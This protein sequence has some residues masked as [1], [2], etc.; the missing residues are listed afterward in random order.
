M[1][2]G[3][4][5]ECIFIF[6]CKATSY[7]PLGFVYFKDFF[8]LGVK[9]G[10]NKLQPFRNVFMHRRLRNPEVFG[11]F[12]DGCLFVDH[13]FTELQGPFFKNIFQK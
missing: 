1:H 2:L 11:G 4:T 3:F 10:V 8:D 9:R 7:V 12:P 6:R 13:E 5:S